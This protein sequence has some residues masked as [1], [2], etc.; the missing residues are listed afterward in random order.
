MPVDTGD[1]L[2]VEPLPSERLRYRLLESIREYGRTRLASAPA[3]AEAGSTASEAGTLL[4]VG[5]VVVAIR[6]SSRG[7]TSYGA[8]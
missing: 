1:V 4:R 6:V 5:R 3:P 8:R 7:E 2:D